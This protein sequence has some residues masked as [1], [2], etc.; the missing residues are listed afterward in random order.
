MNKLSTSYQV[1]WTN[2]QIFDPQKL[3]LIDK[4]VNLHKDFNNVMSSAASCFNVLSCLTKDE[5]KCFLNSF[6]L[7]ID[8][9]LDFP[10]N[11]DVQGQIYQDQ[12]NVIFEW[13]GPKKSPLY[14]V[15][16]SRGLNRTS[17]DAYV[18]A[19]INGKITQII[20]EWK[21]TESYSDQSQLQRFSGLR[22][23]ERL[24]RYST[25]LA[26]LR[27]SH[28]VP[29]KFN[30]EGGL[31]LFDFGYEPF[32]QLLRMTLLAKLTT[33]LKIG[34]YNVEDYR[35]VHL[36]HSDND[37][38]NIL[39]VSKIKYCPSLAKYSGCN[40]HDVWIDLLTDDEKFKFKSG[41]WNKSLNCCAGQKLRD[42]LKE[43]Y[44]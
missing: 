39:E 31:G 19:L 29:F 34:E 36:S 37:K 41:Y 27:K 4:T 33:P 13:I 14:E 18:L 38:L 26:K 6:N 2:N 28:N 16:G 15:G 3:D 20:I 35:V 44:E 40:I 24:R 8:K 42:Y 30:D 10:S 11:A 43:R 7:E 5:L 22:G 32:Y 1:K 17:V 21:F 9:I 12:G 23:V 25:C